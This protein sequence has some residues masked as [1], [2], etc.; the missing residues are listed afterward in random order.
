MVHASIV[1][2]V[3]GRVVFEVARPSESPAAGVLALTLVEADH[4]WIA[5]TSFL[6]F[7]L[8]AV[9]SSVVKLVSYRRGF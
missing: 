1:I 3:I 5:N 2:T 9:V 4:F 7:V 8:Q 6:A